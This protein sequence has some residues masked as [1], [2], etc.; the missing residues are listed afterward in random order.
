MK[1]FALLLICLKSA[2]FCQERSC[3]KNL[4]FNEI[5]TAYENRV[6]PYLSKIAFEKGK[7]VDDKDKR[8]KVI[9]ETIA[10]YKNKIQELKAQSYLQ[11]QQ[12]D[13]KGSDLE[14]KAYVAGFL[15]STFHFQI[16]YEE[17]EAI[18]SEFA[19]EMTQEIPRLLKKK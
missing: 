12:Q 1:Y 13:C 16:F 2:A 8:D 18:G 9:N 15:S 10:F 7:H 11:V 14:L 17:Y 6:V 3:D 5:F 4:I 19:N